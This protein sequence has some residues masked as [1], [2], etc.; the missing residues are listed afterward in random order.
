MRED[1]GLRTAVKMSLTVQLVIISVTSSL[2]D[3]VAADQ[4][5]HNINLSEAVRSGRHRRSQPVPLTA[6]QVSDI[7]ERHNELRAGEGAANMDLMI[8]D[9]SLA[10]LA[11]NWAAR[12][13]SKHPESSTHPE[14]DH[15]GQNLYATTGTM[16]VKRA[17]Q[18][19]FAEKSD[20]D[21][22][23]LQCSGA[24]CGHY[25][26]VVWATSR[27]VGCALHRCTLLQ[28]MSINEANFFV[29]NYRP[30]GNMQGAKPY[31]KGPACSK[32]GGGAGWCKDGLCN[33]E[34][35][36]PGTDCSC[37]AICYNCAKLDLNTCRCSCADGWHGAYCSVVCQDTDRRCN[38]NPGWPP[39]WCN[40]TD[41][42]YVRKG[43]PLMCK[44][45]TTPDPDAVA[46]QC[47]PVHEP[48][49]EVHILKEDLEESSKENNH[50]TTSVK[51]S[52]TT[53]S[54]GLKSQQTTMLLVIIT[55]ALTT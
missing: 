22:D 42:S 9:E 47:L 19:W 34:C 16:H 15:I 52:S 54:V 38:A 26:Q 5:V 23:T 53:T 17:I 46:N 18:A 25:T 36:R 6:Q 51:Q 14:F 40:E 21:H 49:S 31:T 33:W 1:W 3:V 13:V 11:A 35:S 45:C 10:T 12:C 27:T 55:V 20:Y 39:R 44:L 8:Y 29:C 4:S 41:R 28:P 48:G 37:A 24:M 2:T 7:V 32:C 43:C 50:T 30:A